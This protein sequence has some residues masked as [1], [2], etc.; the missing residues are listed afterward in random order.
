MIPHTMQGDE[1]GSC[2][3]LPAIQGAHYALVRRLASRR[4]HTKKPQAKGWASSLYRRSRV[5]CDLMVEGHPTKPG[6]LVSS[7]R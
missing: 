5:A 1:F 4:Y 3:L 2:T 7:Q 6:R